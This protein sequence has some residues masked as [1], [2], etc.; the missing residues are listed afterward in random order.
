VPGG[1]GTDDYVAGLSDSRPGDFPAVFLARRGLP[2]G[3][4]ALGALPAS[5]APNAHI[6]VPVWLIS[7]CPTP[8]PGPPPDPEDDPQ[9][10]DRGERE[11]RRPAGR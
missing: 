4:F 7:Q 3:A 11:Q 8:R 9:A 2:R 10:E 5:L 6:T 1:I